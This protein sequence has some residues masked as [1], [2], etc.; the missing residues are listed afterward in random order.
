M[1][2]NGVTG[3]TG[4]GLLR[5]D[6]TNSV[7]GPGHAPGPLVQNR[8]LAEWGD[9]LPA[10]LEGECQVHDASS[11]RG[12]AIRSRMEN[13]NV[14]TLLVCPVSD[15]QGRLLGGVFLLWDTGT[16]VPEAADMETLA[17]F[18]RQIGRQIATVLDLRLAPTWS[19]S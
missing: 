14:G 2:H 16:R 3:V 4:V 11:L 6:V 15:L 13:L 7:A 1:I 10:L 18:V 19:K 5:Y 9:F 8:P 12:L 17:N